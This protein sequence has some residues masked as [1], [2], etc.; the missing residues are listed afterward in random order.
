M[1]LTKED[2]N[3]W[4]EKGWPDFAKHYAI[5]RGS[6]LI[7]R[8]EGNSE[9]HAV[10]FDTSTVEIDYPSVPVDFDKSD[11]D[12]EPQAIRNEFVEDDSVEILDDLFPCPKARQISPLSCSQPHKRMRKSP[13]ECILENSISK[14]NL[15]NSEP[16][17]IGMENLLLS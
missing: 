2:D 1:K 5:K 14:G 17:M 4:L 3:I 15:Q 16:E 13:N 7:F 12:L 8:Y 6:M 10:I 9:F 11:S